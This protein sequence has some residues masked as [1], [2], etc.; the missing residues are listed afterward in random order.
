MNPSLCD[1]DIC[2]VYHDHMP[3]T[4][5]HLLEKNVLK[6]SKLKNAYVAVFMASPWEL[7]RVNWEW[8]EGGGGAGRLLFSCLL[9]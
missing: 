7:E 2:A 4:W 5:L 6:V 3:D 9:Q 1:L 8:K